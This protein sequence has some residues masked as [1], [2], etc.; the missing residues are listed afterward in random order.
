MAAE[1]AEAHME[2]LNITTTPGASG[3]QRARQSGPDPFVQNASQNIG[4]ATHNP[5]VVTPPV[6][7]GVSVVNFPPSSGD[8]DASRAG[9]LHSAIYNLP[10]AN[11]YNGPKFCGRVPEDHAEAKKLTAYTVGQWLAVTEICI[12]SKHI[13]DDKL[14]MNK[15]VIAA[16]QKDGDAHGILTIG[17]L[18]REVNWEA[19]EAKCR[20][21]WQ[22]KKDRDRF[23]ATNSFLSLSYNDSPAT[24]CTNLSVVTERIIYD[25]RAD[26]NFKVGNTDFW[27]QELTRST[28]GREQE[29]IRLE[30]V[31]KYFSWGIFF[32]VFLQ[33]LRRLSEGSAFQSRTI[34]LTLLRNLMRK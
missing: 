24:F 13:G 6:S 7:S 4:E 3:Q 19:F 25:I 32:N 5:I 26:R 23:L 12:T 20:Q 34:R 8:S 27:V 31:L 28:S 17:Y 30:D 14:K 18:A 16:Y 21:L 29:L 9:R 15:A 10:S 22:P 2:N 1:A 33:I 11:K